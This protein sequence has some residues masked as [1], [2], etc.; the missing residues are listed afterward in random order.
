MWG[1]FG[2]KWVIRRGTRHWKT[3]HQTLVAVSWDP[4]DPSEMPGFEQEPTVSASQWVVWTQPTWPH[5]ASGQPTTG[6]VKFS[7]DMNQLFCTPA[8]I[9]EE[10]GTVEEKL[11][12][13]EMG[14]ETHGSEPGKFSLWRACEPEARPGTK[15]GQGLLKKEKRWRH[16]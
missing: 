14:R 3:Q 9:S 8:F 7:W 1:P 16:R 6:Q 4:E 2:L 13:M 11:L 12:K 15:E 5:K 10:I